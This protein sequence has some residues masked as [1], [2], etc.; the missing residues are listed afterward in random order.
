MVIAENGRTEKPIEYSSRV[1]FRAQQLFI[2]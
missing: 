2:M 1:K